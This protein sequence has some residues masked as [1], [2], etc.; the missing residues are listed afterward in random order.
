MLLTA[1]SKILDTQ[2][3]VYK[4]WVNSQ[5]K[6]NVNGREVA[7]AVDVFRDPEALLI[8]AQEL[9]NRKTSTRNFRPSDGISTLENAISL[10]E[11]LYGHDVAAAIQLACDIYQRT[12][13]DPSSASSSFIQLTLGLDALW[14]LA[15][16]AGTGTGPIEDAQEAGGTVRGSVGSS[17]STLIGQRSKRSSVSSVPPEGEISSIRTPL[18]DRWLTRQDERLLAWCQDVTQSPE[19]FNYRLRLEKPPM[20][21]LGLAF[22]LMTKEFAVARLLEPEDLLS[23]DAVDA[24]SIAVYLIELRSAVECDRR[25]RN[26]PTFEIRTATMEN[27]TQSS[28]PSE[29]DAG[30]TVTVVTTSSRSSSPTA[31]ELTFC[32]EEASESDNISHLEDTQMNLAEFQH[33]AERNLAW[34]LSMEERLSDN[35]VDLKAFIEDDKMDERAMFLDSVAVAE[36]ADLIALEKSPLDDVRSLNEAIVIRLTEARERF[37]AHEDLTAH[38]AKHE[39]VF[40]RCL[41]YGQRLA[42]LTEHVQSISN[43]TPSSTTGDDSDSERQLIEHLQAVQP[44]EVMKML[45][46]LQN[47]WENLNKAAAAGNRFLAGCLLNRQEAVLS[48][49]EVQLRKLEWE[50]DRQ[51]TERFGTT[52]QE[53]KS[54]LIANRR[55]ENHLESGEKL[56][57]HMQDIV[58]LVPSET[59]N[60]RDADL[61]GRIATLATQW[62][63]LVEWVHT[64]YAQLQN[65]L[66][67]WRHF[68]EEADFLAEWLSQLE[69]EA[70]EVEGQKTREIEQRMAKKGE[71][72]GRRVS[73]TEEE[74]TQEARQVSEAVSDAVAA[75]LS[76]YE[77]R[78]AQ[79]LASLDRRASAVREACGDS[80]EIQHAVESHVDAL[81]SRWS[82]LTEPQLDVEENSPITTPKFAVPM[83]Q[84]SEEVRLREVRSTSDAAKRPAD[85]AP[86]SAPE[87]RVSLE[88]G[89]LSLI[90]TGYRADFESRAEK[91]LK[92]LDAQ[93]DSL[94]LVTMKASDEQRDAKGKK[95]SQTSDTPSD[96]IARVDKGLPDAKEDMVVVN[97]LGERYRRDLSQAGE[98]VDELDQLFE[99]IEERWGLLDQLYKKA[100]LQA[101]EK[102]VVT[103]SEPFNEAAPQ[104][105][106]LSSAHPPLPERSQ[107]NICRSMESF[108][109]W[110]A[111]AKNEATCSINCSDG[112]N[113]DELISNF[114]QVVQLQPRAAIVEQFLA[115]LKKSEAQELT[116]EWQEV[117]HLISE[118]VPV[119]QNLCENHDLFI[120]QI[121]RFEKLMGDMFDYLDSVAQAT[122]AQPPAIE[123]QLGESIEALRDMEKMQPT[124]GHLEGIV[125]ELKCFFSEPYI[126][127]LSERLGELKRTWSRVKELTNENILFLRG[128]LESAIAAKKAT[129][130]GEEEEKSVGE[131]SGD[132]FS[133]LHTP[134]Q[135]SPITVTSGTAQNRQPDTI[136]VRMLDMDELQKWIS[137]S[138]HRLAKYATIKNHDEMDEFA[139]FLEAFEK[140]LTSKRPM[141]AAIRNGEVT[142]A[143]GQPVS[144]KTALLFSGHFADL[145]SEY[146]AGQERLKS[147]TYHFNDFKSLMSYEKHWLERIESMVRKSKQQVFVDIG[148]I[149]DDIMAFENLKS[150]HSEDDFA[151]LKK[152]VELLS[153][154]GIMSQQL[155]AEFEAYAIGVTNAL[156]QVVI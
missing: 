134:V 139:S 129:L 151:R 47:R 5:L 128:K 155:N 149:C 88:S 107:Q 54:Q 124:L 143:T 17:T 39:P 104:K 69:R 117:R 24:R 37:N 76:R 110:L 156:K 50:R 34:M 130:E 16:A 10:I 152:I 86:N 40:R 90:P 137:K 125:E 120:N 6:Q 153:S 64:H 41:R 63:R 31:S 94:E 70:R 148:D 140:E 61:E 43:T 82:Q 97:S 29:P 89:R 103:K 73:E 85:S 3:R 66:L 52:V 65:A 135:E 9:A 114:T 109:Q 83:M 1:D 132:S 35:C 12:D 121:E 119:L 78:W 141:I 28:Q 22:H 105:T 118:R 23:N 44:D 95:A 20:Q 84:K 4:R 111:S 77:T 106:P 45:N 49:V 62:S 91:L 115:T 126:K 112:N 2:C 127:N 32:S 11:R 38:L 27:Q 113:L 8:L 145:E 68:E 72:A 7:E 96:V 138:K 36:K 74:V 19:L 51:A 25:R 67:H 133:S 87:K 101:A 26:K 99:D 71:I 93:I 46:L 142:A 58:I 131:K 80:I 13:S 14:I 30:V 56:A 21:N 108:R 59:P 102:T 53:L 55:L 123:A 33:Q 60:A 100:T 57:Q 79:L 144:E 18:L 75:C 15:V 146:A 116:E 42:N 48:A 154:E 92:W 136:M 98:N 122:N 81:V 147:A 150:E